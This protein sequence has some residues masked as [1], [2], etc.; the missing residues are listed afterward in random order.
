MT[1]RLINKINNLTLDPSA[2]MI[3]FIILVLVELGAL[4]INEKYQLITI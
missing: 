3:L 2:G 4:S 1:T